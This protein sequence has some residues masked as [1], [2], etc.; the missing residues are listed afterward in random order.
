MSDTAAPAP[1]PVHVLQP[2]YRYPA[3][4]AFSGVRDGFAC[5]AWLTAVRR[6]FI[7]ARIDDDARTITAVA[8]LGATGLLWWD[9][10]QKPD[11]TSWPEFVSFFRAEFRPAGFHDHVRTLLFGIRMTSSVADYVSR[12]RRYLAILCTNETHPEARTMLEDSAKSCFLAGAPLTLRQ[13]LMSLAINSRSSVSI[14]EMCQAAEQFDAIYNFSATANKASS[15]AAQPSPTQAFV[16]AHAAAQPDP[17]AMELDN[18]RLEINAL[19]RQVHGSNGSGRNNR[20]P[21]A[22]LDDAER[23]RLR[24]RGACFKCRQDGHMSWACRNPNVNNLT[25][26]AGV[27]P[28]SAGNASGGQA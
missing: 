1:A 8:Y 13:M 2:S 6:F 11:N 18:L 22:P 20:Q 4:P 3:P 5:E 23:A 12:T 21:L 17:M 7:G 10:L 26:A 9:G 27:T 14:H 16:T 15:H 28:A 19:R 25:V 24:A